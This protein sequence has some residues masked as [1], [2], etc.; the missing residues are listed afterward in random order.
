[1]KEQMNYSDRYFNDMVASTIRDIPFLAKARRNANFL[2]AGAYYF[3]F[4]DYARTSK[5][6]LFKEELRDLNDF[7]T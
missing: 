1:M 3:F 6:R 5:F 4:L 7:D 2:K